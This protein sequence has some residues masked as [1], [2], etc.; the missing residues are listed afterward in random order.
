MTPHFGPLT[1]IISLDAGLRMDGYQRFK[2]GKVCRILCLVRRTE[3]TLMLSR[4]DAPVFLS[5]TI[6]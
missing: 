3:E 2:S 4:E 5:L 1:E 6:G